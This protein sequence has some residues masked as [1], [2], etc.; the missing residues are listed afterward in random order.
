M[1]PNDVDK[2][3]Q[4]QNSPQP[5]DLNMFNQI[6]MAEVLE[7]RADGWEPFILDV[8]SDAEYQE[9]RIN[10]C[11]L[12][13]PHTHVLAVVDELPKKTDILI[14]CKSGMRSQLAA[15]ELIKA[16]WAAERLYNLEGGIMAWKMASPEDIVS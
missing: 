16:G 8:R 13:I 12:Q 4:T 1:T 9:A 10:G 6:S 7:R 5:A 15:I 14:H 3:A 11:H 2:G